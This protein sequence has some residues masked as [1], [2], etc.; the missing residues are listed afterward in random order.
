MRRQYKFIMVNLGHKGCK[1]MI[2]GEIKLTAIRSSFFLIGNKHIIVP[3]DVVRN[4]PSFS[5]F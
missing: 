2:K 4:L 3:S 1:L 5:L